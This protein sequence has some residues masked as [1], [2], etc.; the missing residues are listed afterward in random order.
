[1]CRL[2]PLNPDLHAAELYAANS[3]DQEGRM[4]SYL[5]YGP[6]SSYEEYL[7]VMN[8]T[9]LKEDRRPLDST[10]GALGVKDGSMPC[11]AAVA[12][13]RWMGYRAGTR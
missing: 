3:E 8:G 9:W 4:W 12:P 13:T 1:M 2:V 10:L 5:A 7:A 11:R 6:F